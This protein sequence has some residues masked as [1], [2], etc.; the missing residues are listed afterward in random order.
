M[1]WKTTI[2]SAWSE[3]VA[4]FAATDAMCGYDTTPEAAAE[5]VLATIAHGDQR[6]RSDDHRSMIAAGE[7]IA[8]VLRACDLE[9]CALRAHALSLITAEAESAG[10]AHRTTER[11]S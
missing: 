9:D 4:D 2:D 7:R 11:W 8:A 1:R 3:R 6:L 10:V 5:A